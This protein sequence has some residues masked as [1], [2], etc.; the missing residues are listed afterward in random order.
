[1]SPDRIEAIFDEIGLL[2]RE[3]HAIQDGLETTFGEQRRQERELLLELLEKVRPAFRVL[4]D[5]T[6]PVIGLAGGR[7]DLR[8][9]SL[10]SFREGGRRGRWLAA[11]HHELGLVITSKMDGEAARLVWPSG[12]IPPARDGGPRLVSVLA[13]LA[14]R[15]VRHAEGN[16]PRRRRESARMVEVLQ[17][18]RTLLEHA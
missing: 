7:R 15:L 17:A 6:G 10:D 9:V 3:V 16:C 11:D 13:E 1:M 2:A 5:H 18:I 8:Q 12:E 14:D 4:A